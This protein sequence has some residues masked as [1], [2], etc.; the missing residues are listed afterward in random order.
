[1]QP[2]SAEQR[3]G[4][5]MYLNEAAAIQTIADIEGAAL[6]AINSNPI[7]TAEEAIAAVAEIEG[8]K[9]LLRQCGVAVGDRGA[10]LRTMAA[11][12]AA[13]DGMRAVYQA[14]GACQVAG[15]ATPRVTQ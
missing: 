12:T 1:M 14:S 9:K 10:Y 15:R 8:I 3:T 11:C 4:F 5:T 2:I 13:Q 7:N 6:A